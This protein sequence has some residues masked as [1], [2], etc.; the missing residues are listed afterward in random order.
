MGLSLNL[1]VIGKVELRASPA[2][3]KV[4]DLHQ[5]NVFASSHSILAHM[6]R[7]SHGGVI[8]REGWTDADVGCDQ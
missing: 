6:T 7:R 5:D 2:L 1:C 3:Y 4:A 8:F